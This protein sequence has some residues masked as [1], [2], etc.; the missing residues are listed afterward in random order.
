MPLFPKFS[1]VFEKTVTIS[2][3][4]PQFSILYSVFDFSLNI[5][6]IFFCVILLLSLPFNFKRYNLNFNLNSFLFIIAGGILY[7]NE[8]KGGLII[9]LSLFIYLLLSLTKNQLDLGYYIFLKKHLKILFGI[10][11]ISYILFLFKLTTPVEFFME[12][13]GSMYVHYFLLSDFPSFEPINPNSWRFYAFLNEPGAAAAI[14]GTIIVKEKFAFKGNQIFWL[15]VLASFSSGIFLA[16]V[17]TYIYLNMKINY[18]LY[19]IVLLVIIFLFYFLG[20]N[21]SNLFISF[22]HE[23][24]FYFTY[25]FFS[26][27]DDRLQYSFL[28]YLFETPIFFFIYFFLLILIPSRFRILFLIMGLYRHHFVLNSIPFLLII[29]YEAKKSYFPKILDKIKMSV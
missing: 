27:K 11:L 23:K 18:V 25:D 2:A 29:F 14:S 16:L 21:S 9:L 1:N 26:F 6:S 20:A 24:V 17:I 10:S 13:R 5:F 8:S 12:G 3:L 28:K 15:T 22:L 7:I 4:L 19:I